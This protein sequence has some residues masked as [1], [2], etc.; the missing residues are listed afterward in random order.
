MPLSCVRSLSCVLFA[1][2]L[3]AACSENS[4]DPSDT[5]RTPD[6]PVT[7]GPE[8]EAQLLQHAMLA[9]H[10]ADG[11]IRGGSRTH[12]AVV[13]DGAITWTPYTFEAGERTAHPAMHLET[14]GMGT[15]TAR[16]VDGRVELQR[17]E[18]VERLRND[19]DGLHQEWAFASAPASG[20]LVV[21]VALSGYT[22]ATTTD[23]G[24][25]FA[26]DH[27]MA[28]Y[29]NAVWT[30]SDGQSWPITPT[31]EGDR[32]RMTV[33]AAVLEATRFPAVLDP[34]VTAEVAADSPVFAPTGA[35]QQQGAIAFGGSQFL[36]V[37]SDNR[38]SNNGDIWGTR[39]ASDGTFLDTLGIKIAASPGNQ[40]NP[41]VAFDG[42]SF[43]VAWE[44]F[45][46]VGGTDSDIV[47]ARV[48]SD[49]SV[50][51]LG[52]IVGTATSET[53]PN[54]ASAGDGSALV[55]WNAAGT[56]QGSIVSTSPGAA[57]TVA[58]TTLVERPSVAF[59]PGGYLVG[60][61]ATNHMMGQL[62]TTG[63]TLSG[64]AITISAPASGVQSQSDATFDGT[65]FDVVWKNG[66]DAHVYGTR[67]SQ[68]GAV[69]DTRM[70]GATTVGGVAVNGSPAVSFRPSIG[71]QSSGCLVAWHDERS[72][73][74]SSYDLYGQLLTLTFTKTGSEIAISTATGPQQFPR[75]SSNGTAFFLTWTD[76][77]S[78]AAAQIYAAS[79][80]SAGTVAGAGPIGTGYNR[81]SALT[82][83]M[84]GTTQGMFW[85][86]SRGG[87]DIYYVRYDSSNNA[88]DTT[89]K[90][91]AS[92]TGAQNTPDATADLGGNTLVV[93][94]DTRGGQNH[95]IYGAR[96]N[97]AGGTT[98]DTSGIAISTAANDQLVPAVAS[99][100]SEALVVW[101]DNRNG[102]FDIYGALISSAGAV[103]LNDIAISVGTGAQ[104]NP[105]V[106]W[107]SASGQFIVAWQD[108]RGGTFQIYGTRVDT[109]GAVLDASGVQLHASSTAQSAPALTSSGTNT[110]AVWQDG[111]DVLGTRLT[112]GTALTVLDASGLNVTG[113]TGNQMAAKAGIL[114]ADYF[115]VWQDERAGNGDIFG[116]VVKT[117]G[118]LSGANVAIST[119]TDDEEAPAIIAINATSVRVAY[120]ARRLDTSRAVSRVVAGAVLQS[121]TV[122]P[123]TAS[124]GIGFT[125][126]YKA[127]ANYSDGTN[128]NV[129]SQAT[130][131]TG[132][133]TV[134]TISNTMGSRGLATVK[135]AG[136]TSVT[137]TF[138]GLN[139]TASITGT[140]A[141]LSSIAVTPATFT[142]LPGGKKQLKATGTFSDGSTADLTSQVTWSSSD[143][144]VMTIG[145]MGVATGVAQ[146]TATI[147]AAKSGVSGTATGT[148]TA[149]LVSIAV[150]PATFTVPQGGKQ[151]MKATGTF[152]DG[153]TADLTTQVTWSSSDTTVMTIGSAGVA[154]GVSQGT[155]TV[156]A[157]RSGI[158]GTAS[159]TVGANLTSI[160]VTPSPFTVAVGGQ[161]QLTAT[162]HYSDGTTA[163]LT[164]QVTWSSNNTASI[165]VGS[166][167]VARG[168]ATGTA[169]ITAAKLGITGTTNGS[170]P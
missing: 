42:T 80:S 43:V 128:A 97:L 8:R 116:Q 46:V 41:A 56:V 12:D 87:P 1:A 35:T 159:G 165:T 36:A 160:T 9:F 88:L 140:A 131:A 132:D 144:T 53:T 23:A 167:G 117:D 157:T 105:A 6:R 2:S 161:Q 59:S 124:A 50:T 146:G 92:S 104:D 11:A 38:D 45:K 99:N 64:T 112:G 69:L 101:Q 29:S 51:S 103:T 138:G 136:T 17:G 68:A 153:T 129:T 19:V 28:R 30:S 70:V 98:L 39:L 148:V 147:T 121:I 168:V 74:T 119:S 21:D 133:S 62:V 139:G 66:A 52:T 75:I 65:N 84:G 113:A 130:W 166:A 81:E 60:Y 152:S 142:V 145:T 164:T 115:V 48:A 20:D 61:S 7:V 57:F 37:W 141:T 169:T 4:K 63:G 91:V 114:G 27:V 31:W 123:A 151:Q 58:S 34:T 40:T 154:T 118:T 125:V 32:I 83:G 158:S 73:S 149:M 15:A 85:R 10:A 78:L 14:I 135:G 94:T 47:G 24:L 170:V 55:V 106:T 54:I 13:Q 16:I 33:P 120:E 127:T 82:L 26:G 107:D 155:A 67:V 163:N 72:L 156:T 150:T 25:H 143:T 100:G 126:Q 5:P 134:A 3:F 79:I 77:R 76:N 49:G 93:W 86:D 109:T 18:V 90:A 111:T 162:G 44:D 71:C 22:F 102:N 95:D 137:A 110:L 89:G 108:N 122:T 96:V